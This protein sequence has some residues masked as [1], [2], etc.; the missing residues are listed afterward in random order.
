MYVKK[1]IVGTL[2]GITLFSIS[3]KQ[4]PDQADANPNWDESNA[5]FAESTLPYQTAD[6]EKIKN[7][8]FKPAILEGMRRQVEAIDAITA[9]TETPTFDNTITALEKSSALLKRVS[10][11]FHLLVGAHT[12]D[13]IKA[14]NQEL[15]PKFAAHN[16]GIYLNDALFQRVKQLH[17][18]Q[19]SLGLTSEQARVLDVYYQEF[20]RSGANLKPEQKETLKQLNQELASL[21][22]KFGDQL[23]AA[24]KSGSVIFTKEELDGLSESELEAFK[25]EDGTYA[26]PLNN[27]TQQ[28]IAASLH[29]KESRK[30][31]FAAG[32]W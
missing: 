7:K 8:D 20:V 29:K 5:F 25:Q 4:N 21:T 15:S 3:C 2:T 12:N 18:Q 17:D 26:I 13:E 30:K 6:F 24:T 23:L 19:A 32:F 1:A 10:S 14:I 9:N 28:P 22:T 16:D 11:V 31:L 27:T